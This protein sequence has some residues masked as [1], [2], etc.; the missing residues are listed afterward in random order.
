MLDLP[1]ADMIQPEG[2]F[3]TYQII[4]SSEATMPMQSEE[5]EELLEHARDSNRIHGISGA[6]VYAEGIFL[7]ILEGSTSE[8][9]ALMAK[10][11]RDLRHEKVTILQEGEIQSARFAG[12]KM[13]YVSATPAQVKRWAGIDAVVG[14][15][16]RRDAS[17]EVAA[18]ELNRTAQFAHDILAL[19]QVRKD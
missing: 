3:V 8:L 18:G 11:G 17:D 14:N 7:Q 4:Y 16:D 19:I 13:A 12:W 10:I 2:A 15:G 6:L 1:L 9:Q 5:L